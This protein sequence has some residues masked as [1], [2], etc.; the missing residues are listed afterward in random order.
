M[1]TALWLVASTWAGMI[2][3]WQSVAPID[4]VRDGTVLVEVLGPRGRSTGSGF[5]VADDR[6]VATAAH[7]IHGAWLVRVR[8]ASGKFVAVQGVRDL[9]E[10]LDMA[11]LALPQ[12]GVTPVTLGD[13]DSVRVGQRLLALGC[14]FGLDVA[15]ADGL[16]SAVNPNGPHRLFQISIPVSPGSSGG[17]VF[18]EDGRVVGLVVSGVR[19]KGAENVNFALPFNYVRERIAA[20]L[21]RAPVPFSQLP[22]T[23][24]AML[25]GLEQAPDRGFLPP[26][27][28]GLVANFAQ[29][30]GLEMVSEWTRPDGVRFTSVLKVGLGASPDGAVIVERLRETRVRQDGDVGLEVHR[31][32]FQVPSAGGDNLFSNAVEFT[33]VEGR[34]KPYGST[35]EVRGE[36]FVLTDMRGIHRGGRAPRGVAP[37]ALADVI[38]AAQDALPAEGIE[39]L[40]LDPYHEQLVAARFRFTGPAT[41]KIPFAQPGSACEGKPKVVVRE[42]EVLVGMQEVGLERRPI[43]VLAKAPHLI[44][45]SQ[46]KC[47]RLPRTAAFASRN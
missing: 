23:E 45:D 44:V 11:L 40:V 22:R 13:S 1:L 19:G 29:V 10:Q 27:N 31:T 43:A 30:D 14:P 4:G 16:L 2:P 26:V 42:V 37:T 17:P 47:L 21:G 33:P 36:Q 9:D 24:L 18:T 39:F 38:L 3:G 15:V 6:T 12:L 32:L 20:A 35:L 28:V 8:L 34:A 5:L 46:L 7:V 41:R 25:A